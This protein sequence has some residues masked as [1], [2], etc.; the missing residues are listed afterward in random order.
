MRLAVGMQSGLGKH[1]VIIS[2]LSEAP[3]PFCLPPSPPGSRQAVPSSCFGIGCQ[4]CAGLDECEST[5]SAER[6]AG[7]L[8]GPIVT[9]HEEQVDHI[10]LLV[11]QHGYK[12]GLFLIASD[13][14]SKKLPACPLPKEVLS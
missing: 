4:V 6:Q 8:S 3:N 9:C 10:L 1:L 13:M 2:R 7:S 14:G 5:S 11:S 12:H